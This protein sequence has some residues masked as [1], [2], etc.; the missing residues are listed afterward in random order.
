MACLEIGLQASAPG[1]TLQLGNYPMMKGGATYR[2]GPVNIHA[3][4]ADIRTDC[5]ANGDPL[6]D[7][8]GQA[9][10]VF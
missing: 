1:D 2:M 4:F 5:L 8:M 6:L 3:D 9:V 10:I 7:G